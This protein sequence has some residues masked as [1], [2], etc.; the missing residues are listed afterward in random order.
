[1]I[2]KGSAEFRSG[3]NAIKNSKKIL[4]TKYFRLNSKL[5]K[6]SGEYT[7]DY[8]IKTYGISISTRFVLEKYFEKRKPKFKKKKE[9]KDKEKEEEFK[10]LQNCNAG[11]LKEIQNSHLVYV[12]PGKGNL[13]YCIDD[14]N[15]VF[16][17]T[18]KQR[19]RE[20]QRIK[21][22]R[23][24]NEYKKKNNLCVV[25]TEIPNRKSCKLNTFLK[26]LKL[27]NYSKNVLVHHL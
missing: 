15:K 13:I 5:F 25:E 23:T 7:F 19:L 6:H 17:Y 2:D 12:D 3:K 1:M 9:E 27:K 18:R 24:I 14:D 16:R 4:W 26:Y 11:E 10:Y 21:H 8:S 22:Q 20:T